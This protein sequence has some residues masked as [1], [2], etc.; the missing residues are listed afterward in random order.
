MQKDRRDELYD[1]AVGII[2][3][4]KDCSPAILQ[5]RLAVGYMRACRILK[6]MENDGI[7]GPEYGMGKRTVLINECNEFQRMSCETNLEEVRAILDG[8][9]CRID[10]PRLDKMPD[11][12]RSDLR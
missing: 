6:Q 8:G 12:G 1:E 2:S 10:M 11:N 3:E 4:Q 5:R 9:S 7:V